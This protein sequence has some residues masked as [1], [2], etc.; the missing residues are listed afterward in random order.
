MKRQVVWAL[1]GLLVLATSGWAQESQPTDQGAGGRRQRRQQGQGGQPGQP[2]QRGPGGG[3]GGMFGNLPDSLKLTE[4]QKAKVQEIQRSVFQEMQAQQGG[5]A[6]NREDFQKM[7]DLRTQ[8]QEAAQAGDDGKAAQLQAQLDT[9]PMAQNRKQMQERFDSQVVQILTS[10]Q[11]RQFDVWKRLRDSGLPPTLIEK[12]DALKDAALKIPTLAD[13]QKNSIEAAWTHY[14]RA[15]THADDL[16]KSALGEQFANEVLATLKPSQK[17]LL[18]NQAMG[19]GPGGRGG[20]GPRQ[21]GA[22]NPPNGGGNG[23][24]AP[25]G[26]GNGGAPAGGA[27]Q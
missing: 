7:R 5:N 26:G 17:I 12:P 21:N 22:G 25:A 8:M 1:I 23:G 19:G 3:R 20:R 24:N 9:M 2:G 6:F 27:G 10:E 4:D 11:R 15:T 13:V 16:T 14:D 18:S